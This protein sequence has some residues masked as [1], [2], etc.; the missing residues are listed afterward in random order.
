M[1]YLAVSDDPVRSSRDF[2]TPY[3]SPGRANILE[4]HAQTILRD[5]VPRGLFN[6][7]MGM[8]Q[9]CLTFHCA[10]AQIKI[11]QW[12]DRYCQCTRMCLMLNLHRRASRPAYLR[13]VLPAHVALQHRHGSPQL[14]RAH[15]GLLQP[16][17]AASFSGTPRS[18]PADGAQALRRHPFEL[19]QQ[20][21]TA[22][23]A[24]QASSG[25]LIGTHTKPA[26]RI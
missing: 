19:G 16:L 12:I 2:Q 23:A 1:A 21:S 17:A 10:W 13:G 4:H 24:A 15:S 22:P 26:Q 8:C 20:I 6:R 11:G 25:L 7:E 5:P 3:V 9:I 18:L 14:T